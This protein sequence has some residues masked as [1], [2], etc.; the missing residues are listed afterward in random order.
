MAILTGVRWY[1]IVVLICI[2]LMISSDEHLF[3]LAICVSSLEKCLFRSSAHF[4]IVFFFSW[5]LNCLRC[6]CIL[7][8]KPLLI[9]LFANISSHSVG[10]LFI[11]FL[12]SFAMQKLIS[13][14]MSH[15]FIFVFISIALGDWPKKT[16]VRFMSQN[17]LPFVSS[18]SFMESC[19]ICK[20]LSHFAFTFL[21]D[22][23]KCSILIDSHVA[24]QLSQH[25][26][27]KTL[28]FLH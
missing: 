13:L 9:T 10:C 14:I 3:L 27:L 15:L 6:L 16:L 11:L 21:Y 4:L 7:D 5:L 23:R 19:L 20:S 26:L 25:H 8:I 2:S 12:I 24:L 17:V 28:S 18:W 1:L 22:V